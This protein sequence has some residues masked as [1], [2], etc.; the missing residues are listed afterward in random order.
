MQG[1]GKNGFDW[2]EGVRCSRGIINMV[3][4]VVG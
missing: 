4:N 2:K 3:E 1:D